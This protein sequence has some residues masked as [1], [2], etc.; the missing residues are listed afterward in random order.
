[1]G[2][3]GYIAAYFELPP[4]SEDPEVFLFSEGREPNTVTNE[5]P[6]SEFLFRDLAG[7]AAH[8]NRD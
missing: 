5:G 2:H 3:Q 8:I 4:T 6:F 1:M 7:M